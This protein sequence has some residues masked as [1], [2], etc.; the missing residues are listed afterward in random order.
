MLSK[1]C[2]RKGM[3]S[4]IPAA[5]GGKKSSSPA[6]AATTGWRRKDP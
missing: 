5:T 2:S 6:S 1:I 3:V 4:P